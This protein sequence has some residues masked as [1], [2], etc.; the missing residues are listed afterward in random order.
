MQ[1]FVGRMI[2]L[3]PMFSSVEIPPEKCVTEQKVRFLF[4]DDGL[5]H[6]Q[7][8]FRCDPKYID[9]GCTPQIV[10]GQIEEVSP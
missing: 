4:I 3:L 6:A 5:D 1:D 10:V 9:E 7:I 8:M 2:N